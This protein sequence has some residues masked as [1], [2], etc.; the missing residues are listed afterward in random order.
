MADPAFAPRRSQL[1]ISRSAASASMAQ[2]LR[3]SGDAR[4]AVEHSAPLEGAG[5]LKAA[6]FLHYPPDQGI[7]KP[8]LRQHA[9]LEGR[10]HCVGMGS[11]GKPSGAISH[12]GEFLVRWRT[13]LVRSTIAE[14][15][16]RI[17]SGQLLLSL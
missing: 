15:G 4:D 9:L 1:G 16:R 5:G 13:H 11:S 14:G 17:G 7:S 10:P 6:L 8:R 3:V 12:A 2:V